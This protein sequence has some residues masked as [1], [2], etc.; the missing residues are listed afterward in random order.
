MPKISAVVGSWYGDEGKGQITQKLSYNTNGKV[1]NVLYNG[2]MQRGH[3][4]K[5]NN[6][7]HIFHCFGS[8]TF[9]GAD[10][11]WGEDFLVDPFATEIEYQKIGFENNI[12]S[13]PMCRI[14]TPYDICLNQV[15]ELSRNKSKHGSC[16]MGIYE[17]IKRHKEIPLF[18]KDIFDISFMNNLR[19]IEDY[20]YKEIKPYGDFGINYDTINS[21]KKSIDFLKEHIV[22]VEDLPYKKYEHIIFE[23][24][25]GLLLS[26]SNM[27]DYPHL[28]PS[29]TGSENIIKMVKDSD[30]ELH[31]ITRPYVTRHGAGPLP[32]ENNLLRH[33]VPKDLTNQPNNWQDSIRYG[34]FCIKTIKNSITKDKILWD[35]RVKCY[36]DVTQ[37]LYDKNVII[38]CKNEVIIKEPLT[39][40]DFVDSI[41]FHEN[42]SL[43]AN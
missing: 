12:F 37:S 42:E 10:T 15:K 6:N 22:F 33:L 20:F 30:I 13:N 23:G 24:G 5:L 25:Q 29:Y 34:N 36:L 38:G 35:K 27:K 14:V 32:T 18:I 43:F 9:V 41:V 16:G 2:G 40:L 39:N 28:T 21:F 17:T 4:V 11:Y 26:Q 8:G 3:T 31:Y 7:R 19:K 1:L